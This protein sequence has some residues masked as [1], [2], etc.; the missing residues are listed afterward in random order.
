[1]TRYLLIELFRRGMRYPIGTS[2]RL[3]CTRWFEITVQPDH[4]VEITEHEDTVLET[5]G[6]AVAEATPATRR[7]VGRTLFDV[8]SSQIVEDSGDDR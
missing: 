8:K 4:H 1:M 7:Y 5:L 2:R 6:A 3:R